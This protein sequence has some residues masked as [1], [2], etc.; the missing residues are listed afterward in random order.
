MDLMEEKI[1]NFYGKKMERRRVKIKRRWK[2]G[3]KL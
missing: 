1:T 2:D 3:D